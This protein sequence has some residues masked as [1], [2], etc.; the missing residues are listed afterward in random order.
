MSALRSRLSAL[1]ADWRV[2]AALVLALLLA[3]PL[4]SPGTLQIASFVLVAAVHG[5]DASSQGTDT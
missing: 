5:R 1:V 2:Q 3:A 4:L